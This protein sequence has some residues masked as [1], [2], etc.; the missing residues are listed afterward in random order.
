MSVAQET[1][2]TKKPSILFSRISS[3][4][5][6]NAACLRHSFTV[7][8]CYPGTYVLGRGNILNCCQLLKTKQKL[9]HQIT[10]NHLRKQ[11]LESWENVQ[12][13]R[14]Q[15]LNLSSPESTGGHEREK[16]KRYGEGPKANFSVTVREPSQYKRD[17]CV[18]ESRERWVQIPSQE[19]DYTNGRDMTPHTGL[20]MLY[21][22]GKV[23]IFYSIIWESF[24]S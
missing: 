6:W 20:R 22:I 12:K 21:S 7:E 4:S 17:E 19:Q 9:L 5:S 24:G 18:Y 13:E 1:W 16:H 15:R 23:D 3:S 2:A 11:R 10:R 14:L 8:P